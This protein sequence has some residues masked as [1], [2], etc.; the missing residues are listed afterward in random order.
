MGKA[1]SG[2]LGVSSLNSTLPRRTT[3]HTVMVGRGVWREVTLVTPIKENKVM[4]RTET[5]YYESDTIHRL[6]AG[7]YTCGS[8]TVAVSLYA[9]LRGPYYIVFICDACCFL[10]GGYV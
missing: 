6:K 5:I 1:L 4:N 3:T 2:A 10:G 7:L 8:I 9:G